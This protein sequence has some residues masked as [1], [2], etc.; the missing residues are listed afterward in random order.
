MSESPVTPV[1]VDERRRSSSDSITQRKSRV[2]C[3][4]IPR[5]GIEVRACYR[6]TQ[7]L[8]DTG[9]PDCKILSGPLP[10][11]SLQH[12]S[13]RPGLHLTRFGTHAE[14]RSR[15]RHCDQPGHRL[16]SRR[17][18][19]PQC[20]LRNRGALKDGH[21]NQVVSGVS[22][23]AMWICIHAPI[24][25]RKSCRA[26]PLDRSANSSTANAVRKLGRRLSSICG[27]TR[28][29]RCTIVESKSMTVTLM[30]SMGSV[31]VPNAI[32]RAG[33][34]CLTSNC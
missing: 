17:S 34:C 2:T 13:A 30:R 10:G 26:L 8:S 4:T 25:E 20:F 12:P 3:H 14:G 11:Q 32:T 15:V 24:C 6:A 1:A 31:I 27:Y 33:M 22:T 23:V 9:I 7:A 29:S 16:L 19:P 5:T 21:K 18:S 28:K